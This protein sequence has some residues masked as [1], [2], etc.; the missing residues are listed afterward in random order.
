MKFEVLVTNV[1]SLGVRV[2]TPF[3]KLSVLSSRGRRIGRKRVV[4]MGSLADCHVVA[5]KG[6]RGGC[7]VDCV[8]SGNVRS[9]IYVAKGF[10]RN[11]VPLDGFRRSVEEVCSL[12]M[13]RCS[14]VGDRVLFSLRNVSVGVG[15]CVC[16]AS[17]SRLRCGGRVEI[18]GVSTSCSRRR[19]C[20]KGI[21]TLPVNVGV[22]SS[23]VRV[24]S[25]NCYASNGVDD[26]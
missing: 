22:P 2:P 5:R 19:R 7:Q 17:C 10:P 11:V 18:F 13:S 15:H 3:V 21:V 14:S 1:P 9:R 8:S 23:D 4:S 25:S 20:G 12:C 16:N 26:D 6:E 24:V